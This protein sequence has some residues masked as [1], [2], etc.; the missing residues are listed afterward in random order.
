[1][2]EEHTS[3]RLGHR[4]LRDLTSRPLPGFLSP[5]IRCSCALLVVQTLQDAS[6]AR[7]VVPRAWRIRDAWGTQLFRFGLVTRARAW[8][9]AGRSGG[10]PGGR[11]DR[12]R[13]PPRSGWDCV[14]AEFYVGARAARGRGG[15]RA[16]LRL[17]GGTAGPSEMVPP[18]LP[19]SWL[20][21]VVLVGL[22]SLCEVRRSAPDKAL[23][24]GWACGGGDL[25]ALC[26]NFALQRVVR[27]RE[28]RSPSI[29]LRLYSWNRKGGAPAEAKAQL[30]NLDPQVVAEPA[31][32]AGTRCPEGLWPLP[33]QVGTLEGR[34][35]EA[36]LHP[37]WSP[38]WD[39]CWF[40]LPSVSSVFISAQGLGLVVPF[41]TPNT[42]SPAALFFPHV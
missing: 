17:V 31:E 20:L 30:L 34:G 16:A 21:L 32:E 35:R 10:G 11:R 23:A 8:R 26:H 4:V 29:R 2:S 39:I 40:L 5:A 24:A 28:F 7:E 12:A 14:R 22:L 15:A 19:P 42:K 1:M 18:P 25:K 27:A 3:L 38:S 41:S 6:R 9:W 37:R 36:S 13:S 33:P